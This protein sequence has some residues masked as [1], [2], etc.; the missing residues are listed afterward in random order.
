MS[1]SLSEFST[2]TYGKWILAGEHAVLRGSAALAFP[3]R[4]RSLQLS[5]TPRQDSFD[6]EFSGEHGADLKLLFFGVLENAM[7]RL[8]ITSPLQGHFN[9]DS[10]L[11]VGTGLGA[12]A[13]LCGAVA[14]WCCAQGFVQEAEIYEFA[15]GLEDL[16]HGESSGVDLAV[17]LSA[18]GVRFVRGQK[19]QPL[20]CA[21]SPRLYLSYSGQRGMTS[22]C[23]A[24]VKQLFLTDKSKAEKLDL[25]M[26]DAVDLAD[27][28]LRKSES[29]GFES[30]KVALELAGGCFEE[31]GLCHGDL[32][33]HIRQLREAGAVAAKPTGSGGGG[34]VLSLW[35]AEPPLSLQPLLIPAF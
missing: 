10:T 4:S 11:P 29:V 17:S 34:Y 22:E 28:A 15:R 26:R 21:W 5:F 8:H 24:K 12:S 6:V 13:A 33:L 30:L 18:Q 25:Q 20:E 3:L 1:L 23:V 9:L 32:A 14:R 27:Q 31:W 16:F 2:E 19:P 7:A 35:D